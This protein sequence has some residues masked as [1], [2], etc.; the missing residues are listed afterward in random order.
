MNLVKSFFTLT[1]FLTLMTT[2]LEMRRPNNEE[3]LKCNVVYQMSYLFDNDLV[4]SNRLANAFVSYVAR[5]GISEAV[6]TELYDSAVDQ[7]L[8]MFK[9]GTKKSWAT[10]LDSCTEFAETL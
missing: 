8:K 7:V 10:L 9:H 2:N 5:N 1:F 6:F 4:E 3:A